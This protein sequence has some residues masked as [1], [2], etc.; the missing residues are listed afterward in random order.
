[1]KSLHGQAKIAGT[2]TCVAGATVMVFY[3]GPA[4]IQMASGW[5]PHAHGHDHGTS[6]NSLSLAAGN[7]HSII[8]YRLLHPSEA[9]S[10]LSYNEIYVCMYVWIIY[11]GSAELADRCSL[12]GGH[13]HCILLL[14]SH[15]GIMSV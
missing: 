15:S 1:M 8:Y 9:L 14:A 10:I 12:P 5:A 2:L 7:I 4:I 6:N 11:T 13:V 3:S